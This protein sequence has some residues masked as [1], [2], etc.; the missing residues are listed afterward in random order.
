M[1]YADYLTWET[2]RLDGSVARRPKA[3]KRPPFGIPRE[4]ILLAR[5]D[6]WP[7]TFTAD[8][9]GGGCGKVPMPPEAAVEDV[10]AAVFTSLADITRT[11]HGADIEVAWASLTPDSWVG[12]IR[13]IAVTEP[14]Q[15]D[16][17]NE[18]S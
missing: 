7:F 14:A 11:F 9:S 18:G 6:A 2:F 13:H 5:Q 16:G 4:I 3:K 15:T 17:V 12:R 10:Q 1:A 8:D